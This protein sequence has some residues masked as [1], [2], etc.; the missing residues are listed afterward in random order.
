MGVEL[1]VEHPHQVFLVVADDLVRLLV[2]EDGNGHPRPV[3]GLARLI[4]LAQ[5]TPAI[6]RFRLHARLP[7]FLIVLR[8]KPP[9][10]AVPDRVHHRQ[11]DDVI[12]ALQLPRDDRPVRPGTGQGHIKVVAA[13]L[14]REGRGAVRANPVAEGVFLA[15]K[16]AVVAL[17]VGKLAGGHVIWVS[18]V[19][20]GFSP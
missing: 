14:R 10:P 17:F 8:R 5:K 11:P 15:L 20:F 7:R 9:P 19:Q 18:K 1:T 13:R 6:H 16:F 3:A 12:Q 2:P 4:R